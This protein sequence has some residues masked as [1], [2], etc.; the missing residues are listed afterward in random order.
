MPMLSGS[1]IEFNFLGVMLSLM[2]KADVKVI[3]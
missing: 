2:L 1:S 3:D